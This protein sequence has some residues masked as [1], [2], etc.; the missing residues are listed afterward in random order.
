M[1]EFTI[2]QHYFASHNTK[3]SSDLD[4]GIGD[5]CAIFHLTPDE[6]MV[7]TTDTLVSGVHF[8]PDASPYSIGWKSLAVNISDLAAMGAKP[9]YFTLALTLP[10]DIQ[11]KQPDFLPEFSR[12]LFR[13]SNQ[14]SIDLI[15]GD[16]THGSLSITITAMGTLP[17]GK[18]ILR[19]G[20]KPGDDIYVTGTLGDAAL[21][22][23]LLKRHKDPP[24]G[25]RQKLDYPEPRVAMG[26]M[27]QN[28][29][30]A[31]MDISDGL[32]SDL[33]HILQRSGCNAVIDLSLLPLSR[34]ARE[35]ARNHCF[36]ILS[37][38]NNLSSPINTKSDKEQQYQEEQSFIPAL[39]GG[40]DYELCFTA[41]PDDSIRHKIQ[42]LSRQL[43]L[44]VTRIGRI[45]G[46]NNFNVASPSPVEAD[47]YKICYQYKNQPFF[48]K[49]GLSGYNH[50]S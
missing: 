48:F 8:F 34:E 36:E 15:G 19:S 14:C 50:F 35:Y 3:F 11:Q 5:D 9:R 45:T 49:K 4:L 31:M 27:L 30:T 17:R 21:A 32:G 28:I 1:D 47:N 29:A 2:I 44:K 24:A 20:A 16:T 23:E 33:R 22:V 26:M 37:P 46:N 42:E 25:C 6:E 41:P 12:G 10:S 38:D 43:N 13:L 7:I 39:F 40:D 18:A